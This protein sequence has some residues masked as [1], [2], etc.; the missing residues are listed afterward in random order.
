ME[1]ITKSPEA[2]TISSSLSLSPSSSWRN[3]LMYSFLIMWPYS[4]SLPCSMR[5][6]PPLIIFEFLASTC[7]WQNSTGVFSG[8]SPWRWQNQHFLWHAQL[9]RTR[10]AAWRGLWYKRSHNINVRSSWPHKSLVPSKDVKDFDFW[11]R[12]RFFL[13]ACFFVPDI[14]A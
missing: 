3:V 12:L 1:S 6:Q 9:H 7:G 10:S 13:C 2:K 11:C 4:F 5:L 8:E 14:L